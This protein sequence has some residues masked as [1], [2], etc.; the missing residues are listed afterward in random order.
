MNKRNIFVCILVFLFIFIVGCNNR[1][2]YYTFP[3]N[4]YCEIELVVYT[5]KTENNYFLKL[6][7]FKEKY[8]LEIAKDEIKWDITYDGLNYKI[9]NNKIFKDIV[10]NK[11]STLNSYFFELDLNK[12]NGILNKNETN[13]EFKKQLYKYILTLDNNKNPIMIEVYKDNKIIKKYKFTKFEEK[14]NEDISF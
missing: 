12:F 13:I 2:T 7:Y 11:G 1:E 5:E 14:S 10:L 8:K 6:H 4:Y 3:G 9:T